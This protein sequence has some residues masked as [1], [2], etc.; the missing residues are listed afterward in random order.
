MRLFLVLLLALAVVVGGCGG[1]DDSGSSTGADASATTAET[2]PSEVT[3]TTPA[4]TTETE[5]E[6]AS[7][8]D[9]GDDEAQGG[10][11]GSSDDGSGGGAPNSGGS[12]GGT[13]ASAEDRESATAAVTSFYGAL[14]S[15]DGDKACELMGDAVKEQFTK[16]LAR[17]QNKQ[18]ASCETLAGAIGK[19]YPAQLRDRLTKLRVTKV[20]VDGDNATVTAKIPGV[21]PS[22]LPL[23]RDGDGWKI[24]APVGAGSTP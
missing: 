4:E 22:Q 7:D 8:D 2:T 19:A 15:G 12:G 23:E 18:G 11:S 14:S 6:Q 10:G 5:G 9:A 1:D 17:A 24:Q 13:P 20:T 21:P 16:A 3:E